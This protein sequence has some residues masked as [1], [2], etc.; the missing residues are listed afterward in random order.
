MDSLAKELKHCFLCQSPSV[1]LIHILE[2]LLHQMVIL[3]HNSFDDFEQ[4][5]RRPFGQCT[6]TFLVDHEAVDVSFHVRWRRRRHLLREDLWGRRGRLARERTDGL[7]L[8]LSRLTEQ[9][10]CSTSEKQTKVMGTFE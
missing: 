1:H 2:P 5:L 7:V 9:T 3:P 4:L 8:F 10:F 6:L